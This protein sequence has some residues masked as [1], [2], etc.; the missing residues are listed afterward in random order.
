MA[1]T[2]LRFGLGEDAFGNGTPLV[3]PTIAIALR[4]AA[5]GGHDFAELAGAVAAGS[6]GAL[7]F[8]P[9]LNVVGKEWVLSMFRHSKS[10]DGTIAKI[11]IGRFIE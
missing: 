2:E 10:F 9:E 1:S 11:Q 8:V 7:G 3:V 5:N 6:E 4:D